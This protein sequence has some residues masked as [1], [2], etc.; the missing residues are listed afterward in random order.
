MIA[1]IKDFIEEVSEDKIDIY[2]EASI[3]YEK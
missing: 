3:Q 1:Y 2:N